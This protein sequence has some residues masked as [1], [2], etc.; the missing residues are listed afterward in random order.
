MNGVN[1]SHS[2]ALGHVSM[3]F[4]VVQGLKDVIVTRTVVMAST[5]LDEHHAFLHDLT[6]GTLELHRQ[7]GGCVWGA[8]PPVSTHPAEFSPVGLHAGAARQLKLDRLGDFRG[9]DA[10][11]TLLNVFFQVHFTGPDHAQATL[12]LQPAVGVVIGNPGGEAHPAGLGAGTP[13]CGLDQAV[14]SYHRWIGAKRVF[15]SVGSQRGAHRG[16]VLG[17]VAHPL[18]AA[19]ARQL[20][21]SGEGA[22][23]AGQAHVH[24][25]QGHAAHRPVQARALV[26]AAAVEGVSAAVH[27]PAEHAGGTPS[28]RAHADVAIGRGAEVAGEALVRVAGVE[29]SAQ[30]A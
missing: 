8:A 13:L 11:F 20:D 1:V 23:W 7:G 21:P 5:A 30:L 14:G 25:A 28:G 27:L 6:V 9:P 18:L 10:L 26:L 16:A 22:V 2:L 29:L 4:L 17:L 3:H 15:Q 24:A 19:L 12:L